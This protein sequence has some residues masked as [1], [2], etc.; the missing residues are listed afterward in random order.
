MHANTRK[1]TEI[2]SWDEVPDFASEAEEAEFWSTHSLGEALL[3]QMEP[4]PESELSPDIRR[5]RPVSVRL[6][7]D[8]VERLETL[9]RTRK[10]TLQ[11]LVKGFIVDGLDEEEARE[12]MATMARQTEQA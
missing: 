7:E 9:A 3:D 8:V 5:T 10:I 4:I 6:G 1:L 12:G 11:A 2:H